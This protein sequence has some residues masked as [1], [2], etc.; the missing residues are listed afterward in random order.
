MNEPQCKRCLVFAQAEDSKE[1]E[2]IYEYIENLD[3][4]LKIEENLN[5]ERLRICEACEML[6]AGMCRSCGC[7]VELRAALMTNSCPRKK[8]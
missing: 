4:T 7:Y 5:A 8:W 1:R 3:S 6:I 2:K